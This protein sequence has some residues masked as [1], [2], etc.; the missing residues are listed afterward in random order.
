[1][2]MRETSLSPPEPDRTLGPS[3]SPLPYHP[4]ASIK[5]ELFDAPH[6]LCHHSLDKGRATMINFLIQVEVKV[7]LLLLGK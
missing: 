1:M 6:G 3:T 7:L 5:S 2:Q 4:R